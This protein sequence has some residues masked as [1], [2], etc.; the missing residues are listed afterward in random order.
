MTALPEATPESLEFA[1]RLGKAMAP[2]VDGGM[3]LSEAERAAAP[4][5]AAA[6]RD[7]GADP[8][9]VDRLLQEALE[10]TNIGSWLRHDDHLVPDDLQEALTKSYK[11]AGGRRLPPEGLL[12]EK[13]IVGAKTGYPMFLFPNESQHPGFPHVTVK[14]GNEKVNVSIAETPVVIAGN[15]R[16]IGIG[17]VLKA[18]KKHRA[19]LMKEWDALRPDDQKLENSKAHKA[20][21]ARDTNK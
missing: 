5:V 17:A 12:L 13:R 9:A 1:F 8:T 2:L 3:D 18:V 6:L 4:I 11:A 20:K 16:A 7:E 10:R 19:E 15:E 21:A 14:I